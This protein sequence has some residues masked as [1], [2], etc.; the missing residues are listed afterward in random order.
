MGLGSLSE[1]LQSAVHLWVMLEFLPEFS[2]FLGVNCSPLFS[3]GLLLCQGCFPLLEVIPIVQCRGLQRSTD[4]S[5]EC[6]DF[7]LVV[8]AQLL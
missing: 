1:A 8:G 7:L 6:I 2:C 4:L 3:L 5:D